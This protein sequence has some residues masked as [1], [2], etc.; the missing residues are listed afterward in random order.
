MKKLFLCVGLV[1]GCSNCFCQLNTSIYSQGVCECTDSSGGVQKSMI[2]CFRKSVE[3]NTI[4]F[5]KAIIERGDTSENGISK[6]FDELLYK[7]Q[8]DLIGIC[9]SF[10]QYMD[11][12]DR[13]RDKKLNKDSLQNVMMRLNNLDESKRDKVYYMTKANLFIQLGDYNSALKIS[14]SL[15]SKNPADEVGLL[16]R[17]LVFDKKE[18]YEHS[19][20]VYDKLVYTTKKKGYMLFAALAKRRKEELKLSN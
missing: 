5:N 15:I 14:D 17:A 18:D 2:D 6:L 20:E 7:V 16:L 13:M 12:L 3:R 11:S 1:L 19:S 10:Y 8:I 9:R 4:F